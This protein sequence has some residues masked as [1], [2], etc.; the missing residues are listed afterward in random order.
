MTC[1]N[2]MIKQKATLNSTEFFQNLHYEIPNIHQ[3]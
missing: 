3:E 2:V 1:S